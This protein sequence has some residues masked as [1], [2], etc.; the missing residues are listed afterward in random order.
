MRN[1]MPLLGIAL[2]SAPA[3]AERK[4]APL[5]DKAQELLANYEPGGTVSCIPLRQV[6]SSRIVD[7][8][9]IIYR[10]N[11]RKLFVNRPAG[12]RCAGLRENRA[13]V[14]R[15]P[16]ANLCSGDIA[17]VIDPPTRMEF[18]SCPLG[19]FTEYRRKQ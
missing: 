19:T 18:G 11:S 4:E 16:S 17:Q 7:E 5:S 2:L 12:G 15:S 8:T 3:L 10:I 9:A 6:S 14:T 1:V 13:I